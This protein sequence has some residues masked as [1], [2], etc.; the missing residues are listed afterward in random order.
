MVAPPG[1]HLLVAD[2]RVQLGAGPRVNRV[3]PAVDV[4]FATAARAAGSW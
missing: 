4:L 3:R 2:G 1:L